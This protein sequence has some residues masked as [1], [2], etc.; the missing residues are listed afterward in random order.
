MVRVYAQ[1]RTQFCATEVYAREF[2]SV[3]LSVNLGI[4]SGRVSAAISCSRIAS[5]TNPDVALRD[6]LFPALDARRELVRYLQLILKVVFN[7]FSKSF[8][9]FARKSLNC[10]LN[11]LNVAAH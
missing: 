4:R 1:A 11:F 8:D 2:D 5:L 3:F 10:L 6:V 9:F 7:P